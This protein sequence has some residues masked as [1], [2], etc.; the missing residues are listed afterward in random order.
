MT[1]SDW[2]LF[3]AGEWVETGEWFEVRAPFDGQLVGRVPTADEAL[4]RE[5][6][7]AARK[8]FEDG[9]FPQFERAAVLDRAAELLSER[10]Q[11][12]AETVALEAGKPLK[13][14]RVEAERAISTLM[15]SAVECR[16]LVG[17]AVA[18]EASQ[19]GAGKLGM[20]F[21]VPLGVVGA[22]TPFNFPLNLVC[23][24]LGPAIAAGNTIVQK[25]ASQTP[26]SSLKLA[27]LLLEAGLPEGWLSVVCGSG[28]VVGNAIVEHPDIAL[29]TF[30]GSPPVGWG[31]QSKVPHKKV[32][33]ELGSTAP[34]IVND[35]G[36][37]QTA[38]DKAAVHAFSHAGQSCISIQ[39]ILLHEAVAANFTDRFVK[40]VKGL[41]LGDPLDSETD[42]GPVIDV[43]SRDRIVEWIEQARAAGAEILTGGKLTDQGLIEPTVI[44][45]PGQEQKVICQEVF[46]PVASINT[47]KS[48]EEGLKLAN[49]ADFGLQVGVFTAD[50]G[51]AITAAKTL[52]F[53]GVLINEVP[54]FRAD[55]MPYGGVKDSGNTR[56]GPAYAI[57][58][59]TEQRFVSFQGG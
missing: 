52:E 3:V 31:I 6:V 25:P 51:R 11:E 5:A 59:M 1:N 43:G 4:V 15:F 28:S 13:Q 37:W 26:I 53:G 24:K 16:K 14:A 8:A 41:K 47:F 29:I 18:M 40:S 17:E 10:K 27:Q 49:D 20:I 54:T 32:S 19:A 35:D 36:D 30:T 7:R 21:R 46:G 33:L 42:L 57:K 38:A 34:L 12:F 56:E 2:K 55:Q 48:F 58:E 23:H 9:N 50:L 39:R 45:N 22:I 44:N